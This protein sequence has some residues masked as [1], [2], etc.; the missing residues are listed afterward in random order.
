MDAVLFQ[1]YL[2]DVNNQM[3][4]QNTKVL[5][6]NASSHR[7]LNQSNVKMKFYPPNCTSRLQLLD[8]GI[9]KVFK[10]HYSFRS[11]LVN[12]L[13]VEIDNPET[14]KCSVLDAIDWIDFAW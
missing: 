5:L 6:E 13:I 11:K 8:Q 7:K 4:R 3:I 1:K 14:K 2:E 12:K 10:V 9:I